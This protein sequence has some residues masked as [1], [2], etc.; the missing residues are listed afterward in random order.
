MTR[1]RALYKLLFSRDA[2]YAFLIF[3][4]FIYFNSQKNEY[5][6]RILECKPNE[7]EPK[8]SQQSQNEAKSLVN[9]SYVAITK[10]AIGLIELL[11]S[12]DQKLL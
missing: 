9:I 4:L 2:I 11:V 3:F 1:Y 8:D 7:D 12:V 5:E 6:N 10:K